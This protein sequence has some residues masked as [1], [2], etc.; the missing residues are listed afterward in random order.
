[1]PSMLSKRNQMRSLNPITFFW[2]YFDVQRTKEEGGDIKPLLKV[3]S[4]SLPSGSTD[5]DAL[6]QIADVADARLDI[7]SIPELPS[8][9]TH[10]DALEQIAEGRFDIKSIPELLSERKSIRGRVFF[11][12]AG[13]QIDQIVENYRARNMRWWMAKDG[14]VVDVVSPK[15][16]QLSKFDCVAGG[17]VVRNLVSGKLSKSALQ[18]IAAE[19]DSRGFP[20]LDQLQRAPQKEV[21]GYNHKYVK[22]AIKTFTAAI[23]H[24]HFVRYVR[25]RLYV[26]RDRYQAANQPLPPG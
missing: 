4:I 16:S 22:K 20:V 7:K 12:D 9:S 21:A 2:R 19:L 13:R 17:L 15:Q 3:V 5:R 26:A 18:E 11:G 14:L 1:M 25:R 24:R 10:R 6:G 8:G 23:G